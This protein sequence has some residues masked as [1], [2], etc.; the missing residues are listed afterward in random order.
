MRRCPHCGNESQDEDA[1]FCSRCGERL[2]RA[3]AAAT[4]ELRRDPPT[5]ELGSGTGADAASRSPIAPEGIEEDPGGPK[6]T[7]SGARELVRDFARSVGRSFEEGGWADVI[8]AASFGFLAFVVAGS[9]LAAAA[10]LQYPDLGAEADPIAILS[11]MVIAGV[12]VMRT[13]VSVGG[14]TVSALPLGALLLAG[15]ALAWATAR[16]V[17]KQERPRLLDTLLHG[18]KVAVPFAFICWLAALVFRIRE[19]P[20]PV[21]AHAPSAAFLAL[22]W[23]LV[24][25]L[26][27]ALVASGRVRGQVR[28]AFEGLKQRKPVVYEGVSAGGIML[29]ST[30]AL[31][32]V[33]ALLWIIGAL[34]SGRPQ[35]DFGI[36]E[37]LA[38]L[39]YVV[40]FAPNIVAAT[41]AIGLG[42][43][44]DVGAQITAGGEAVG[45][46]D[47]LGLWGWGADPAPWYV[48]LL[49]LVPLLGCLLGG[50]AAR[51][52]T[53]SP[54]AAVKILAL[55]ALVYAVGLFELAALAEAR[56]GAGLVRQRGFALIAPHEWLTFFFAYLWAAGAGYAGWRIGEAQSKGPVETPA[57]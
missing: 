45:T 39:I 33:A 20:S 31:A 40:A 51:R 1:V 15:G 52:A 5:V 44:V 10:K 42:A 34:A 57:S 14:V 49:I 50:F 4:S 11:A 32:A 21:Y 12:G 2:D 19:D 55:A 36:R 54:P 28:A 22:L 3:G 37:A 13:P 43:S 35:G 6:P 25:G 47:R 53:A 30:L 27:G 7:A 23:A 18:A 56:V 8:G 17:R 46:I 9:L 24:F 16:V 38:A 26:I 41:T 29:A 48:F